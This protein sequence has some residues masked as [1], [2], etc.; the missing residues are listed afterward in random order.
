MIDIIHFF[1]SFLNGFGTADYWITAGGIII[2]IELIPV[3]IFVFLLLSLNLLL[4]GGVPGVPG[5][6]AGLNWSVWFTDA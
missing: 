5:D 1:V 6:L 4:R 2:V 3:G